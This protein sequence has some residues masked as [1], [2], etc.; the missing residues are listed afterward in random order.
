MG[1]PARSVL[2]MMEHARLVF[3]CVSRVSLPSHGRCACDASQRPI[4]RRRRES[5]LRR[6]FAR[7]S[8]T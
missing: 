3:P 1:A 8:G 6:Q 7:A 5:C 4:R 2:A